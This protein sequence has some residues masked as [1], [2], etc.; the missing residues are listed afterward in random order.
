MS[1]RRALSTSFHPL[2]LFA[3]TAFAGSLL[4]WR[5]SEGD[6]SMNR[7]LMALLWV[8]PWM[9]LQLI[10]DYR[11]ADLWYQKMTTAPFRLTVRELIWL[12][13]P[14]LVCGVIGSLIGF[15]LVMGL[16]MT[17][18]CFY[19]PWQSRL[20]RR[21]HQEFGLLSGDFPTAT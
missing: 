17:T 15:T 9:A 5:A 2:G 13:W 7:F 14:F 12:R 18:L 10:L 11:H 6:W 21:S 8:C 1:Q 4:A 16:M 20:Y 3:I 19:F